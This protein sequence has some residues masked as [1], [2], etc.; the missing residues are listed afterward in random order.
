MK[1]NSVSGPVRTVE[2]WIKAVM[3]ER[4]AAEKVAQG[5]RRLAEV[6]MTAARV[7]A[8]VG[9]V[10][11]GAL[12]AITVTGCGVQ[13][14]VVILG[15]SYSTF[16]GYVP[17]GFAVWYDAN[18]KAEND[19]D[20]VEQTWWY[21]L[22]KKEH[23][24]LLGNNSY[25]GSTVCNTGY[26]G[27]DYSDRSFITRMPQTLGYQAERPSI[28]LIF[29]GTNDSWADAPLGE[30]KFAGWTE[31]DLKQALPAYCYMLNYYHLYAP[32][33]RVINI[34]NDG[35][36]PE[37]TEGIVAAAEHY[38]MEYLRL[39]GI[40]KGWGHPTVRGMHQIADALAAVL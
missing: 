13:R 1:T 7:L 18:A 11:A 22:V 4:I 37:I 15:D 21:K 14:T 40:D 23:L 16:E 34:I 39:E 36:K 29:G 35:L 9:I 32:D 2:N 31:E 28:I 17:E 30:L 8:M 5:A 33:S 26:D 6:R 19:V 38:G 25:S 12:G 20:A 3:T 24:K 27:A 10:A